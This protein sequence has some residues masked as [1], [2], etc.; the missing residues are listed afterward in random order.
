MARLLPP[1]SSSV[2]QVSREVGALADWRQPALDSA[3]STAGAD[4]HS[5][6]GWGDAEHW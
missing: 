2:E 3:G 5:R 1:E 6:D 4:R